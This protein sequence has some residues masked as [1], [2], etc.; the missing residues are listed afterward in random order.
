MTQA[1]RVA[2][3]RYR[4]TFALQLSGY[5]SVVLLTGLIGG[6]AMASVSAGRRTQSSY[7][8]FLASTNPSNLTMAVFQASTSGTSSSLKSSIE[9]L[10]DV[11]H[12]GTI[13]TLPLID[14]GANGAPRLGT[15]NINIIGSLDGM[16]VD[17]DRL[18]IL[19][20]RAANQRR[21]DEV[22]MNAGAAHILG[23]H[24]GQ[25]ITLG[26]Y[27]PAQM[28][29]PDFGSPKVKP[30]LVVHERL[31][32]IVALNTQLV[33]D[34]VD[35]T[36]GV[37]VADAALVRQVAKP[38]NRFT[39]VLYGVQLRNGGRGI[40]TL[41]HELVGLV[42]KGQIY[43]FHVAST[44]TSQV[45]LAIKPESVALGA[46]GAIAA[47][48][49]LI[50]AAQAISRLLRRGERDRDVLRAFGASPVT[51]AMEGLVGALLATGVGIFVAAVVAVALSP[52]GPLGPVRPV[53]PDAGFSVD[54][55]VL[56]VGGAVLVVA[57]GAIAS[58]NQHYHKA[59]TLIKEGV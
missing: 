15:S 13:G 27:T 2:W 17:Q 16:T 44:V 49:C 5:L 52:L 14:L 54:W 6:V 28:N 53:Y 51:L 8:T 41:Q 43:E 57:L 26:L 10:P 38:L 18:A 3:Y 24:V 22:V 59:L 7:P 39:P 36:Y 11:K 19:Q 1:L 58:A 21:A 12:V 56:G 34:D 37:I 9:R 48:A 50:L 40:A 20:G 32:G 30:L 4:A 35:L 45:E 23:V 33:Q 25:V 55:T 46:F 42:P 47:L 31:V 29:L